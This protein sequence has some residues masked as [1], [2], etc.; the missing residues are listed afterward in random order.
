MRMQ[1]ELTSER[2]VRAGLAMAV[3]SALAY[4]INIVGVQLSGM[5]GIS[6][7]LII[8]YRTGMMLVGLALVLAIW[9]V[10][11]TVAAGQRRPLMLLG[12]MSALVGS[13]YLSSVAFLPVSVAVVIFY[14]FPV[15][16]VLAEPFVNR[17]AFGFDR[18]VLAM[19]AFAG[20]A[21]VIG[22][23]FSSLD[24]RGILLASIASVTAAFQFFSAARCA[25][26][27]DLPKLFWVNL[28]RR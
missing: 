4:G 2:K 15:I 9:R 24:P 3:G 19:V 8:F 14:T 13:A 1:P 18:L 23:Q 17:T 12:V 26:I 16:V 11:L 7:P 21:L 27:P 22:P 6:G 25:P 28:H 20:V 10:T 5:S